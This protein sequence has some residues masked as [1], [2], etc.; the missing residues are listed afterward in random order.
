MRA[1]RHKP[2]PRPHSEAVV[3]PKLDRK[4]AA[5]LITE[6]KGHIH[7]T[8]LGQN[9][10][11]VRATKER[12]ESKTAQYPWVPEKPQV[13]IRIRESSE[14]CGAIQSI[15]ESL[16]SAER[17][18]VK[19]NVRL[20][21]EELT[22]NAMY[23]SI[24]EE[25]GKDSYRRTRSVSLKEN[26][27][28]ELQCHRSTEGAYLSVTDWGDNLTLQDVGRCLKRCYKERGTNQIESKESGAG[29]GFFMIFE[30]V[31]HLEITVAKKVSTTISV[32]LPITGASDPSYFSFNFW[33]GTNATK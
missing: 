33:G 7:A 5:E 27:A 18:S 29:L 6:G 24:R 25:T 21:M 14:R 1:L 10:A 13:S 28:I 17:T 30:N 2:R 11:C 16:F 20:I 32:W 31:T 23:H 4:Q 3:S 22:S 12:L 26:E 9:D 15:I 19:E 8:A